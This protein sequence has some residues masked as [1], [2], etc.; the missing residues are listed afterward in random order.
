MHGQGV[1]V[2]EQGQGRAALFE[3]RRSAPLTLCRD[4]TLRYGCGHGIRCPQPYRLALRWD[5]PAE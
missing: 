5:G 1:D 2:P 4:H 3:A